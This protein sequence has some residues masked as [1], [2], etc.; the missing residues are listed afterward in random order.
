MKRLLKQNRGMTL[1][2]IL[3]ALS[4][5]MIIIVG[6][7]PVMLQAYEGLYTAGE[8][9]Q[10]TYDAKTEIEDQLATRSSV[11][12]YSGF[13]VNFEG[14]GEV[15]KV[16]AKRAVSSLKT[17]L[18]TLFTNA[19]VR[20]YIASGSIVD[21]N[22]PNHTVTLQ[23]VNIALS[24]TDEIGFDDKSK[25]SKDGFK[26][27]VSAFIP[28][29]GLTGA[30]VAS[31]TAATAYT[32]KRQA[33]VTLVADKTN[34]AAGR[35]GIKISSSLYPIDFTTSPIKI[36]VTYLDENGKVK[37]VYTYLTIKTPTIMF[38]GETSSD[39][40]YYT[41]AGVVETLDADG[42]VTGKELT[43]VPRKM[44]IGYDT[45]S[46]TAVAS[47][48]G[49][50]STQVVPSGTVFKSVNWITE[51]ARTTGGTGAGS[52]NIEYASTHYEPEYY[53]LTG[54]NGAIYRTYTFTDT[55]DITGKVNLDT[56]DTPGINGLTL[57]SFVNKSQS[58]ADVM[59][60]KDDI[61]LLDDRASSVVYP[62]VW[63]GDF[64]HIY[65]YSNYGI[66]MGYIKRYTVNDSNP[67]SAGTWYTEDSTNKGTGQPGFYSN[68]ASYGYYY[69]G[70]TADTSYHSMRSRKI[71]YILTEVPNAMRIGG[72]LSGV[73]SSSSS[74]YGYDG[75]TYDRIWERPI[76]ADGSSQKEDRFGWSEAW[77]YYATDSNVIR[78]S[79]LEDNDGE[80][81]DWQLKVPTYIGFSDA[82]K[83]D[84][85]WAQLRLKA[86]T[87]LSPTIIYERGDASDDEISD[88][89]FVYNSSVNKSKI[90]VT[91]AIYIPATETTEAQVFYIGTVVAYGVVNQVDNIGTDDSS[92]DVKNM[93]GAYSRNTGRT[94]SYWILSNDDGNSITV[95]KT[96]KNSDGNDYSYL[97]EKLMNSTTRTS[98]YYGSTATDL[99]TPVKA[100]STEAKQFFI[101]QPL[102]VYKDGKE[103]H[104]TE[105]VSGRVFSDVCFT[106]GYTSNREMLYANIVYG[107]I[108]GKLVQSLK[109]CEPY[110]FQSHYGTSDRNPNLYMNT[111]AD[112]YNSNTKETTA[113]LNS[114]DNDYYNV[115]FPGEMYNLTKT[116]TKDNVTVAVGYAVAGSTYSYHNTYE[117]A[118]TALG[119]IFNDGVISGMVLGKDNAFKSLLYFKD[120]ATFD[121][122]SL[123]N[124]SVNFQH[125]GYPGEESNPQGS[126]KNYSS[127]KTW[128]YGTHARDSVQ[129][130]CVDISIVDLYPWTAYYAYYADNKGRV[131]RSLVA[132]KH[133]DASEP[134]MM[135][136][137]SDE[138]ITPPELSSADEP[139][140]I[141]FN[142]AV[143][144]MEE[145]KINGTESFTNYFS[146]IKSIVCD[147]D[148]IIITGKSNDSDFN[149]VVGTITGTAFDENNN[150][151]ACDI[152][153]KNARVPDAGAVYEIEDMAVIGEYI[154]AVG[155]SGNHTPTNDAD[156]YGFIFA[157]SPDYLS[158]LAHDGEI[159]DTSKG[160]ADGYYFW[161]DAGHADGDHVRMPIYAIAGKGG[162]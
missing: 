70:W 79:I 152:T 30:G 63:G 137:I 56:T 146:E 62:A 34:L 46:D 5:L 111:T 155:T 35:I 3:V 16:N 80:Y 129:F 74:Q 55:N 100:N 39:I 31:Q 4:L 81:D 106:M 69:N 123:T 114:V 160:Y 147:D 132:Y 2:E 156:D 154:Y 134:T 11:I 25:V 121:G 36:V 23:T 86:L 76:K 115:W 92:P 113:Y 138:I 117:N 87:T 127:Y 125:N 53:V 119:G 19:R 45:T 108:G 40:T 130:T 18:E 1:M 43:A 112:N 28:Q 59:G 95:Y 32:D 50:A 158:T 91:D 12:N 139:L 128:D 88:V 136:Y 33:E 73:G 149:I 131:F 14:L 77:F 13:Q 9:T 41:S 97:R 118:S 51:Y 72:A 27:D 64:S 49:A 102:T 153:W 75:T 126:L 162:N 99:N 20:V 150:Q 110:Y 105:K 65:G 17:S 104:Y 26:V 71:S 67:S 159:T 101:T 96:S 52:E 54:T 143:G 94:S 24:S 145:I 8:Y 120:N 7:T 89:K 68:L 93:G 85:G 61:L 42:N 6:T 57:N 47:G 78:S 48:L 10:K 60:I 144:R 15:A 38:A 124:G 66:E 90:S 140:G 37:S 148:H 29:K 161:G 116:A 133:V 22:Q 82:E 157:V 84:N 141:L 44:N 109:F 107:N 83:R 58:G 135:N 122:N 21:D 142:G 103:Y 98:L 151:T